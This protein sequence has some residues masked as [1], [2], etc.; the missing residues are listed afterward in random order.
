LP[1]FLAVKFTDMKT[2]EARASGSRHVEKN[3]SASG[4]CRPYRTAATTTTN[5]AAA[6][7]DAAGSAAARSCGAA[8]MPASASRAAICSAI[9]RDWPS[10]VA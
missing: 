2:S 8:A 5:G 9:R 4:R 10:R 7:S 3:R 1:G 6:R